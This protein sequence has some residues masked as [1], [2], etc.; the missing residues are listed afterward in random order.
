M[1]DLFHRDI[2][3][4]FIMVVF[5][6]MRYATIHQFQVLTERP[7]RLVRLSPRLSFGPNV[8]VGVSPAKVVAERLGHSN[9][10]THGRP[11]TNAFSSGWTRK[12]R[13]RP[14][15]PDALREHA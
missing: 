3:D 8:W 10:A 14:V 5:N 1:S 4:D 9:H 7:E 13:G 6:V 12:P 11:V 15:T 2:P